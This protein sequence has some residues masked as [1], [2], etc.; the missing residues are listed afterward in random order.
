MP[1]PPHLR[2]AAKAE[3]YRE[4]LDKLIDK[5]PELVLEALTEKAEEEPQLADEI[6]DVVE[7]KGEIPEG[8]RVW[9]P[10]R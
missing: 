1:G 4:L 2:E 3:A 5:A 6:V 7:T 8:V 9:Q 10:R